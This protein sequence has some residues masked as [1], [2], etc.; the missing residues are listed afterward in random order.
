MRLNHNINSLNLYR[1]YKKN[2]KSN[3]TAIDRISSGTKINSAKDNPNKIGQSEGFRIQIKSLEAAQ[4]N[5]QDGVSMLRSAD[6]ALQ[7]VNDTLVRIK[8]LAVSA[9]DGSKSPQDVKTIQDEIDQMK[10]AIDDLASNTEFNGVKLIGDTEVSNNSYPNYRE[11]VTGAKVGDTMS[12]PLYNVSTNNLRDKDGNKFSDIDVTDRANVGKAISMV[13]EVIT[14][15]TDIRARYGALENKFEDSA[16]RLASNTQ[17]VE[18]AS[19]NIRD[20]DVAVEMAEL[21]RTQILNQTQ[22]ALIAQ[23]NKF[24][25]DALSVL[26]RI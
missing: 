10:K 20:T 18:K 5:L 15:I 23:S 25:Q 24:P 2:L 1:G 16:D 22:I 9:S 26:K 4:R 11:L 21:A 19:S 17:N 6:G 14:T 3:E 13:D 7:E 12:V 8:E